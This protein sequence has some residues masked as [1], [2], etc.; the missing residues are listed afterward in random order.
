M[1]SAAPVTHNTWGPHKNNFLD[2]G[3]RGELFMP[4]IPSALPTSFSPHHDHTTRLLETRCGHAVDV[5][6]SRD[7]LSLLIVSVPTHT[8]GT[9]ELCS[10][11][12][13]ARVRI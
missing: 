8:F 4:F 1:S 9:R 12:K 3:R 2:P 10:V 13:E 5:D 11:D 6:A 7:C